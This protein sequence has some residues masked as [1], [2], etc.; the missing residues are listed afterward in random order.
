[1]GG[2]AGGR[3]TQKTSPHAFADAGGQRIIE[4]LGKID[5]QKFTVWRD[6]LQSRT[7]G[8]RLATLCN[9]LAPAD[10]LAFLLHIRG[11]W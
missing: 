4:P 6:E 3:M 9:S 7:R 8:T 5:E 2:K 11:R 10:A 1:M